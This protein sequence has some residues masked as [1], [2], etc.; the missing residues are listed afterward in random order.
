[1][2]NDA[3]KSKRELLDEYSSIVTVIW[4][5]ECVRRVRAIIDELRRRNFDAQ[6]AASKRRRLPK[7]DGLLA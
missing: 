7:H 4:R 5:P 1:V 2:P 6:P 3:Q